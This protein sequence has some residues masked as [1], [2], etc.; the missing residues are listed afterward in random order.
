MVLEREISVLQHSYSLP[1][2]GLPLK[3]RVPVIEELELMICNEDI[4]RK[5]KR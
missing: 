5:R 4:G 2:E 1:K 3:K